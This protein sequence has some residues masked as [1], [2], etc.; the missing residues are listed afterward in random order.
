VRAVIVV[1]DLLARS[2]LMEAAATAGYAV[3]VLRAVPDPASPP[4]NAADEWPPDIMVVDLD[5]AGALEGVS[6]WCAALPG[7]R[8]VGYAFHAEEKLIA[9]ARAAGV[10]VVP[11]GATARPARLFAKE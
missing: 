8:V 7:S 2:R 9:A 11:H 6:A 1:T 10:E 4:Q 5:L 3:T